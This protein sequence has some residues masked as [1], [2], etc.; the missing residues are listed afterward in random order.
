MKF[1]TIQLYIHHFPGVKIY[2][3][4]PSAAAAAAAAAVVVVAEAMTMS[5]DNYAQKI[6]VLVEQSIVAQKQTR[7]TIKN[8]HKMY[9][10]LGSLP[11]FLVWADDVGWSMTIWKYFSPVSP[12][13]DISITLVAAVHGLL[14]ISNGITCSTKL[15]CYHTSLIE[16]EFS[17][18]IISVGKALWMSTFLLGGGMCVP[19]VSTLLIKDANMRCMWFK[20]T[21]TGW[22]RIDP[23]N[24]SM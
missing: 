6:N 2:Y 22:E 19:L 5:N 9:I 8:H 18:R 4:Y 12:F 13:S 11:S 7:Q 3:S 10:L 21:E 1:P 23:T 15:R 20:T 24:S 14:S 17:M 16:G